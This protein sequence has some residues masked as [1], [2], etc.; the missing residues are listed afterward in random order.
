MRWASLWLALLW[1]RLESARPWR[2]WFG[3]AKIESAKPW[4]ARLGRASLESARLWRA[5][6]GR[7]MRFLAPLPL[8]APL[9]H[10]APLALFAPLPLL[11]P[12]GAAAVDC[13]VA[14]GGL[15]NVCRVDP[16][17]ESIRL[18]SSSGGEPLGSFE[19]VNR[20]LQRSGETLAFAMNAGMF[21]PDRSPVGLYI[22][23]GKRISRIVRSP[24]PGNFGLLPNGVFCVSARKALVAETRRFIDLGLQCQYATQ[25]GPMLVID[26]RLHPRFLRDSPHR[27]IRNGVGVDERG[28]ALFAISNRAVTF[29]EFATLFQRELRAPNAL[30]LDGRVSKMYAPQLGLRGGFRSLVDPRLG[31]IVGVVERGRN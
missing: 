12:S 2:A 6:L 31:P 8:L 25:S 27:N 20:M 18:F 26:G 5:W 16:R 19:R 29:H 11:L 9:P 21:H 22:E 15:Y 17:R 13:F 24:G 30:Y 7:A 1:R 4:L 14:G 28:M 10:L 23:N 3:R